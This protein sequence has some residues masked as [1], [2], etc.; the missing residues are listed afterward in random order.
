MLRLSVIRLSTGLSNGRPFV[1]GFHTSSKLQQELVEVFIDDKPVHVPPGTTVLQAAAKVGVEIPRFCYH[2]RLAVAG[3]C[4]MCLVEIEK[5]VKPVAACAM[6][7]MKGWRIKTNS[8]LT[9]K[10]REGVMEFL[11]VNHPLDC[12]ICDQGGEC[13]LQD[14]SMAFGSDRSR[15]VDINYSGK[16]AVEDKDIG[17]L[18]KTIMT[19]CIHC[20]RCIRF[21]SEVAGI[22]DLGT[23]G[24]GNDM[25]VGTYVEK[26][27]LSEL[28]GNIID[29]CP[30]GALT[31]KP[32]A[33]VARPW[34]IRSTDSIDVLDAV[35]SNI[36]IS[37]RTNEVLR[38]LPRVNEEINEEWLSDKARFSYDGLKRQRLITPMMKV[39]G[40]LEAVDWE[41]ALVAIAQTTAGIPQNKCAAIA[42]KLADAESLVALKDL[43]NRLGSETLATEQTFPKHG[44]GIDIRSSYLLN[45]T[46]AAIEEADV[47]LLI[48]T[49]PR[50][51][52]PLVNTRL[53]KG[54][55]HGEQTIA[56][57]GQN[58]DLTYD[59]EHLGQSP[60]II[61]QLRNGT[62]PFSNTLKS[63]KRPLVLLGVEQLSRKD[64][65]KIISETQLLAQT[66]EENSKASEGWKVLNILHTNASQVA[67][68]DV[69]YS[70]TIEDVKQVQPKILFLLGADD[71]NIKKED[72]PNTFIVY[73]GSHGDEG[74]SIADV[75]LPGAAYTEKVA[76]YVNTE[77]R[78]QQTCAAVTPPGMA[79]PDWKIIRALSEICGICLPYDNLTEL[80][81]R[82][83]EIAPHLV[84]YGTVE[85]ANYISQAL[86]LSKESRE[87]LSSEPL[88]MKQKTLDQFFMTDAVSRA[89]PTM[90]KCVQAVIKQRDSAL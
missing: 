38:I 88:E 62:H 39:N 37:H 7:V 13:D 46:I 76:T 86:E 51:E 22:D 69:G 30:V 2:E 16:R 83:E 81:G 45:N 80:S 63:A 18:I 5:Q 49:N 10:A 1:M 19:R 8:D 74:A 75:I 36:V 48:G 60:E 27:F 77:G 52:A 42:G 40:K 66:L 21:A 41:D 31:S 12:P 85:P 61:T 44:A 65:T 55:L 47:V 32:Y 15:F 56:L 53:R 17:P 68:L 29:L 25:Q 82:L 59:Y 43:I 3:N 26:M 35:G 4:R 67:A 28:S 23:T 14:Q 73:I 64:G 84:R 79:R 78:A 89:S 71:G 20:T 87:P 9:R 70:S 72:F 50:Y 90:A 58:V 24:R 34:E 33:F 57:I 54:Y 11:L 6:P